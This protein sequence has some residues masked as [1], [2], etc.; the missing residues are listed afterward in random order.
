MVNNEVAAMLVVHVDDIKIAATKQITD[1]VVADLNKTFPTKHLGE[2][3]CFMGSEYKKDREKGTLEISQTQFIRNVVERL[4]ITKTIPIPASPSLDLRH[5]SDEDPAV[6]AIYREMVGSLMWIVNQT[7]PDIANAV[8]AVARFSHDP[9]EINDKAARKIIK[10]LSATAHLGLTFRKDSKL[11]E[12]QLDY[13]LKTYVDVD[14]AHKADDRRWVSGVAVCCGGTRVSW[15][16]RTQ[17]CVILSTTEAEYV[18][19]SDGVKEALY[20]RG[21]LV[22]L[23]PSLGSPRIGVFEDNKGAIDLAKNPLSSS[24][25]KHID[26]RYHFLR[27][28]VGTGG[29]SVK[30][31]RTDDQHA[32]ILTK[33]IGK[34]RFEKTAIFC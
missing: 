32:N 15:F 30:Y 3:T 4:G 22:F 29:L 14:Y 6:D 10:Y 27:E 25:S 21:V 13:D 24:N 1:S 23:M 18:A 2:V 7:R 19:M 31:L 9:K 28:L 11:E 8:R 12:V 16:S 5:V 33:A 26:V 17:E 34:E 20:V